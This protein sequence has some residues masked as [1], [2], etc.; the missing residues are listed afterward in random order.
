MY[1]LKKTFKICCSHRLHDVT[2]SDEENKKVFGRCNNL[3]SHGHNYN[4]TLYLKSDVLKNGMIMNFTEI[5]RIFNDDIDNRFDHKFL[6][7]DILFKNIVASA[8]NMAR[9]F[10]NIL[11]RKISQLY[12]LECEET[13]GASALWCEE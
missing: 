11:K 5:K 13:E 3:P 4:I 2:I 7:D 8:E 6:N 12:K 9:I 10:F 1:K